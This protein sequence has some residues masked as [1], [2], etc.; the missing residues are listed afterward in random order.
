[1]ATRKDRKKQGRP[2][3]LNHETVQRL[4]DNI[5]RTAEDNTPIA[6]LLAYL[7]REARITDSYLENDLFTIGKEVFNRSEPSWDAFEQFAERTF[8]KLAEFPKSEGREAEAATGPE[9]S[10]SPLIDFCAELFTTARDVIAR[11]DKGELAALKSALSAM[12]SDLPAPDA[13]TDEAKDSQSQARP[14]NAVGHLWIYRN[15]EGS[16]NYISIR[17][18]T[19]DEPP[20]AVQFNAPDGTTRIIADFFAG[21]DEQGTQASIETYTETGEEGPALVIHAADVGADGERVSEPAPRSRRDER[22]EELLEKY[23]PLEY[24]RKQLAEVLITAEEAE[25]PEQF[26]WQSLANAL[27]L[28]VGSEHT[29]TNLYNDI[30]ES[31]MELARSTRAQDPADPENL[32]VWLPTALQRLQKQKEEKAE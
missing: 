15:E 5:L 12:L 31:L 23:G 17:I 1:M 14:V 24:V 4:V 25:S 21:V 6:E 27:A 29:P 22:F 3:P 11:G 16:G 10:A 13:S 7:Y 30:T 19:G 26:E 8:D 18:P 2:M 20:L 9:D 32:R 28:V